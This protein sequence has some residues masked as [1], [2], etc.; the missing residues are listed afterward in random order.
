MFTARE[1]N[2]LY[3]ALGYYKERTEAENKIILEVAEE[4]IANGKWQGASEFEAGMP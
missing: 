3:Y 2:H 4:R 1:L